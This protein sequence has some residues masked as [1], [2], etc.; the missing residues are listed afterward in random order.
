MGTN[1]KAQSQI[2]PFR[3]LLVAFWPPFGFPLVPQWCSG[4]RCARILFWF[5]PWPPFRLS[6]IPFGL[7]LASFSVPFGSFLASFGL[8]GGALEQ[9]A[10]ASCFGSSRGLLSGILFVPL[11]LLLVSL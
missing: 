7:P 8:P 3:L 6:L 10:R 5:I 11:R 4:A 2:R 1:L 9:D